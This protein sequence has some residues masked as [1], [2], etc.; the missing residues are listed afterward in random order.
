MALWIK[1][2]EGENWQRM[3]CPAFSG[4]RMLA[5]AVFVRRARA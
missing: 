5:R 4:A 2:T 3:R 1:D